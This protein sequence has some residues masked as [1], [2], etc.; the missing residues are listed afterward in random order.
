MR[1]IIRHIVMS[2]IVLICFTPLIFMF[3]KSF[4][5]YGIKNY[6]VVLMQK[7]LLRNFLNS[8]IVTASTI[9]LVVI[10]TCLAAFAFSKL[11]FKGKNVIYIMILAAMMIPAPALIVPLF[12]VIKSLG[13]INS[14]LS[15][16]G[17]YSALVAPFNLLIM[18]SYFDDL[19]DEIIECSIIDGCS[20]FQAFARILLPLCTPAIM[21]II[22][23]T[24]LASWNEFLLGFM[25]M[26]K[27]IMQ[28]ITVI[29]YS[30][31]MLYMNDLPKTFA[32]LTIIVLPI[33][34][35]YAAMQKYFEEGL[36]AGSIKG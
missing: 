15:L 16:I 27:P 7:N 28:T 10:I 17:T 9:T 21:V 5:D 2:V 13:L 35:A 1:K 3:E 22:I 4:E 32:A 19:P 25:F 6:I 12:Q 33:I 23:F 29:P 11:S 34:I 14:Y 36:T 8:V 24:F 30:F 26:K 20:I 18:K 31:S